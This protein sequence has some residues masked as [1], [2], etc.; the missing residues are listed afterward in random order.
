MNIN[1][2]IGMSDQVMTNGKVMHH[3]HYI[4]TIG[5]AVPAKLRSG[6]RF[7][8]TDEVTGAAIAM[9]IGCAFK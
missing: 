1:I 6:D 9:V 2:E 4:I 7:S 8:F 3:P 5:D